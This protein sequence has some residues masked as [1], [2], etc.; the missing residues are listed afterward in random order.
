MLLGGGLLLGLG[1]LTTKSARRPRELP[2]VPEVGVALGIGAAC[3]RALGGSGPE[4][5]VA[6]AGRRF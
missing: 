4:W 2:S 6:S 5:S 1:V 3:A